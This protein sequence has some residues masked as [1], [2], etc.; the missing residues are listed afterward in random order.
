LTGR[1]LVLRT[2]GVD[3]I[4]L[5]TELTALYI[6]IFASAATAL[7]LMAL[8][9]YAKDTMGLSEQDI[10]FGGLRNAP[11]PADGA[12]ALAYPTK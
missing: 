5:F 12:G 2:A 4:P 8:K 9:E 10:V 1:Q 11:E 7:V 3:A 6:G